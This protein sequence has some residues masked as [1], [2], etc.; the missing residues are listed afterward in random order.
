MKRAAS[1][2]C[3]SAVWATS[4]C[5]SIDRPTNAASRPAE[6]TDTTPL[7]MGMLMPVRVEGGEF[8]IFDGNLRGLRLID[9]RGRRFILDV[10]V[11]D[12]VERDLGLMADGPF[13][14]DGRVS[15]WP[16]GTAER[17]LLDALRAE[18]NRRG[19]E[20]PPYAATWSNGN[21]WDDDQ[22]V[23]HLLRHV[24]ME[25]RLA[26]D[27]ARGRRRQELCDELARVASRRH[28]SER[29]AS[30]SIDRR[31]ATR[32]LDDPTSGSRFADLRAASDRQGPPSTP[33]LGIDD[34]SRLDAHWR[35]AR[36]AL[37]AFYEEVAATYGLLGKQPAPN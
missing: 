32:E 8:P 4:S 5:G 28:A 2:I 36:N 19:Y 30:D 11:C 12:Q 33:S 29:A 25:R 18:L 34:D 14:M 16:G 3:A 1:L 27:P 13:R 24:E 7:L 31:P 15:L 37:F 21:R 9:Q 10:P 6:V 20:S 22:Q 23:A 17:A 26:A 35:E